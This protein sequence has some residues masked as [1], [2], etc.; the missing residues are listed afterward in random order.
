M[1]IIKAIYGC[2]YPKFDAVF[3]V[4]QPKQRERIFSIAPAIQRYS[5]D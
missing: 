1:G 5:P 2:D 3:I 4:K